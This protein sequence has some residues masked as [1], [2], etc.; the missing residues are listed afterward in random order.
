MVY[1][2][3]SRHQNNMKYKSITIDKLIAAKIGNF[4]NR[5]TKN[6][7][8][9]NTKLSGYRFIKDITPV[10]TN[11]K[12]RVAIYEN[13]VGG[14][15][16][17]KRVIYTVESMDSL[18]LQNEAN[19]LH[20]LKST[21]LN[22]KIHPEYI[23]FTKRK[24]ES[25]LITKYFEGEGLDKKNMETRI[26]VVKNAYSLMRKASKKLEKSNFKNLPKR[27]PH[28]YLISFFINW[29]RVFIGN[30]Q[31]TR[32]LIKYGLL[33]YLYYAPVIWRRF[34][35]GLVHRDIYPDNILYSRKNNELRIIDW[36]SAT[37]SDSLYDL[38]QLAMIY[39]AEL[40]HLELM[41]LLGEYLKDDTQRK[42]FI[43]LSIFNSIQILA[44]HKSQE[45]VYKDTE[46][47]MD[48]LVYKLKPNLI[49]KRALFEIINSATLDFISIFYRLT[50]L[51]KYNKSKKLILCYHSVGNNEWRYTVKTN[52]FIK[53]IEFLNLHYKIK[54]L[55]DL[56]EKDKQGVSISFDDGYL[57]I[58]ENALP[59]L[60]KK[61]I[62]PTV[63]VLGDYERVNRKELDNDLRI[64]NYDQISDLHKRGW[65]IGYHTATHA[66]LGSLSEHD[67]EKEI[68]LGRINL[69]KK[70]GFP[71]KYFAYPKGI[72]SDKIIRYV[73]KGNYN[74]AFTTD[75]Y[76]VKKGDDCAKISRISIEKELTVNQ[77]EA[78]LSPLGLYI[79]GIYV[80]ILKL[81][82]K[83]F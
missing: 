22:N 38:A 37:V 64:V 24:N 17:A 71:I 36:E 33:F 27:K 65:E 81:K 72:Y 74:A 42:R 50:K 21:K 70:L 15:V 7:Y 5:I 30:P 8:A 19:I 51:N 75:G 46:N 25:I 45:Q 35:Y 69:E 82:A 53:Q 52:N 9:G 73:K 48:Y 57:D 54:S 68:I 3:Q 20:I 56:L 31:R 6:N 39:S 43:G 61:D 40:T 23:S 66:D 32:Q 4:I 41:T 80:K 77:L 62:S 59:I 29:M 26:K 67:L 78:L 47:F 2:L 83:Y 1:G 60:E 14:K 11:K 44:Y 12:N 34:D 55:S 58:V 49:Y 76:A 13:K 16:V 28:Y 79:S 10:Y 63:F 18:Y